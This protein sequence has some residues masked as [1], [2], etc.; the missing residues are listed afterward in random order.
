MY[1]TPHQI[2]LEFLS[3]HGLFGSVILISSL[4]YLLFKILI[5]ILKSRNH[6]QIGCFVY[7]L[8][9]FLPVIPSGSFFSSFTATLFWLNFSIMYACNKN[10]NVFFKSHKT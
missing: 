3:E 2:Y 4:F 8:S 10:T 9:N 1:D 6:I 7:I 5:E